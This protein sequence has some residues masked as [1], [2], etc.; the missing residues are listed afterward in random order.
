M[1]TTMDEE[2]RQVQKE[3]AATKA[4]LTQAKADKDR[5]L[6]LTLTN[7]LVGL[8]QKEL[9]L[10]SAGEIYCDEGV[11]DIVWFL[12]LLFSVSNCM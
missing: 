12:T 10:L 11:C 8:N 1:N 9:F 7:L 2:L 4:D 3:I 5:K 6:V